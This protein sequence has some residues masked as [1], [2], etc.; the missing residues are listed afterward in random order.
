MKSREEKLAYW[1][2]YNKK[3]TKPHDNAEKRRARR[4]ADPVRTRIKESEYNR[5]WRLRHPEQYK[6]I[7]RKTQE[8]RKAQYYT[9]GKLQHQAR[10][11]KLKARLRLYGLTIPQFNEMM[12]IQQFK[13]KCCSDPITEC[14]SHI[15]HCHKVGHVRAI[16]CKLCNSGLGL[17]KDDPQRLRLAVI[18]L[19]QHAKEA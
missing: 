12:S 1:R 18:Y 5:Q 8:R 11:G 3:R 9:H 13:C 4:M 10:N 17:F 7:Q 2:E 6:E 15:D 19:E 14:D 16:L